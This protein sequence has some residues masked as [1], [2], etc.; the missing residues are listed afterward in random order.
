MLCSVLYLILRRLIGT[1]HP[2]DE[3]REVELLVLRHQLK[4]LRR[5]VKRPALRRSDRMLLS[6]AARRLP[7]S[8]WSS[9]VVGPDTLLRWHRELVRRKWTYKRR[10]R[11]GRPALGSETTG[12]ILRLGRE[13]PRWGYQRIRGELLKLGIKVSSTTIRSMMLPGGLDPAPP[14]GGP[15]WTEFLGFSGFGHP[16]LRFLHRGDHHAAHVLRLVLHRA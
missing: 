7:R 3:E 10:R 14:R 8:V 1:G 16:G 13:N 11:P 15:T 9:F 6:A 5:Q 12:L 4:V 2:S